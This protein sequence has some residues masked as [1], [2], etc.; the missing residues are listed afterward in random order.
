MKPRFCKGCGKP[1]PPIIIGKPNSSYCTK[2]CKHTNSYR[3]SRIKAPSPKKIVTKKGKYIN[4]EFCGKLKYYKASQVNPPRFCNHKCLLLWNEKNL[5]EKICPVC[6]SH[7]KVKRKLAKQICCS[8]PCQNEYKRGNN[9]PHWRGGYKD[10]YG[11]N[12]GEQRR[13]ARERDNFTCQY[14]HRKWKPSTRH[15]EVH[16]KKAFR[17]FGIENYLQANDLKNLITLCKSCHMKVEKLKIK[18]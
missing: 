16:H 4:C 10:Y 13:K 2:L 1:L 17:E 8:K 9:N 18:L 15:F 5:I 6:L 11:P 7:F 14:C 12:W 3:P